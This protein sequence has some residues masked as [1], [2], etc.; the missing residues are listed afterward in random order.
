MVLDS[1]EDA[2]WITSEIKEKS[3]MIR[4]LLEITSACTEL[5]SW[6]RDSAEFSRKRLSRIARASRMS[7][8]EKGAART[9][10][11]RCCVRDSPGIGVRGDLSI[12]MPSG[13][14]KGRVDDGR[15]SRGVLG[16][17]GGVISE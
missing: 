4:A 17:C 1:Q 5:R 6:R 15:E 13:K 2:G 14:A 3:R 11:R 9:A 7:E 16:H 10:A 12:A 8:S